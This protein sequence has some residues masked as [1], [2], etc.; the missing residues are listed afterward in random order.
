MTQE[1]RSWRLTSST[2]PLGIVNMS[3]LPVVGAEQQ[4]VLE[5]LVSHQNLARREQPVQLARQA[6]GRASAAESLHRDSHR[7]PLILATTPATR[8]YRGAF[9]SAEARSARRKILV[10]GA[11]VV[12]IP[13]AV[14]G[15]A[16][17]YLSLSNLSGHRGAIVRAVSSALGRELRIG[18][19][20]PTA[21]RTGSDGSGR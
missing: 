19:E 2:S 4:R 1:A 3:P 11:L 20:V 6:H 10:V 16:A 8:C 21:S 14:I 12:A 5:P 18:G 15:V 17:L 13:V 7:R 9:W